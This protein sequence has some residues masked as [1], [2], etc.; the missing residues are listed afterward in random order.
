MTTETKKKSGVFNFFTYIHDHIKV[1][2]DSK[3]FAGLMII[4]LNISSKFVNVKLSKTMESYLKNT[5][6]RQLLVF[7]IAWMGT[8]DVF[9][10]LFITLLFSLFMDVLFNEESHFCILPE[11]FTN[12]HLSLLE[13]TNQCKHFTKEDVEKAMQVLEKAKSIINQSQGYTDQNISDKKPYLN[14]TP[15]IM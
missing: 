1:V 9:V 5:F 11:H 4:T 15:I 7:A 12:Y 10:A 14:Q 8:R 13:D 3:I 6:S 2:N